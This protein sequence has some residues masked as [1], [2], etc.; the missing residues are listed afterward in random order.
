MDASSEIRGFDCLRASN[1]IALAF[2]GPNRRMAAVRSRQPR[3]FGAMVNT[4]AAA[5]PLKTLGS[6]TSPR[7]HSAASVQQ[8]AMKR[9]EQG[10]R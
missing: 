9:R 7:S 4:T 2:C 6:R 5:N 8:S 10:A 3:A 1:T